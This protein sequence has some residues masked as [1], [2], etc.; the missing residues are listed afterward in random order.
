[1]TDLSAIEG[2]M[3]DNA[4]FPRLA[5]A[6]LLAA[7]LAGCTTSGGTTDDKIARTLVAPDKYVLYNCAQIADQAVGTAAREKELL[8]LMKKAGDGAAGGFVS[9]I[10]YRPEYLQRHGEMNELRNAAA[11]KNCNSSPGAVS[12]AAPAGRRPTR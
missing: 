9:T 12:P 5:T 4:K 2:A 10:A 8:A 6:A 7:M 11:A 1:L 3:T